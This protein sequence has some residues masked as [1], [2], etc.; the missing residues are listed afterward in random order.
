M[1]KYFTM[2]GILLVVTLLLAACSSSSP[3]PTEAP[4]EEV[5]PTEAPQEEP[6]EAPKEE[7]TEEAAPEETEDTGA[8]MGDVI[9]P[10]PGEAVK[11]VL[12]PKF[13]GILVF[14]QANEGAQEAAAELQNPEK[15]EF[16][17]PTPENSVAG[18]I[19]IVTTAATQGMDA[20]MISNNAGDQIVP[21]AATAKDAGMTVVTWDS[22]I[23][24]AENEDLFIA[25]VDF[26][27][28]GKVMADMA[29]SIMGEDGGQFAV[30]S[31]S[32]DASN[33]NA[34]IAALEDVLKDDAYANL[35]LVDIVYGND[36]SEDSYNQALAL[37]DK[38]PDLELI[39]AP[40]TVGIAAAAKAM[41]DEGLCDEVKVSGLGLPA[42]ML[43]YT[44][45][46]CAPE[47][48]L[49][50][51]VDL[52][53]LTYY[54]TYLLA[55]GQMDAAEGVTF[56][57]GRMGTYTIE[58]DPTRDEG[59]RVLMGPFTV[60]NKD[61]VEAAA[62]GAEVALLP[63]EGADEVVT[64]TVGQ[65]IKM[66]LLPKFLGI[67]VFDQ[68]NNGAQEAA[69][70][71][72]NPEKLEFLGPTPENSVAGQIDIVTTAATQGVDAIM[73]SNNAGDQIVP[74]ATA[75]KEAGMT[76]VTWDSPIPSAEG[77]DIFIAQVDFDE[78][79][80]VM[81]DMARSIMGEDGG[82]FAVLSASPDASNQNAW[83]AALE[84][85]L[86]DDAYANLEL[87]DIVYG[88]DQSEDSYNQ[89]L[90]LVDKYPDLELIMAPTTVGIAAAAK[91][92]QDEGLCDEVKVSGLGLPAEMVSYTLNGCAPEFALWSFDDLGYLTYYVTYMLAT[93]D[94]QGVE[95]ETFEA[96]RMG[97]YTIEK[98]P[99]RD[100][101]LR[102]LMGPFTVYTA[103]NVEDA[104]K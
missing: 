19:D 70:E 52:G 77:E 4:K 48:A 55:T 35:E 14:D 72:E 91:A 63:E 11:M 40:T 94:L 9:V 100:A 3:A 15:L 18:Q 47:F 68:A 44:L 49:W 25:Q 86:Q 98:D 12:L 74:A 59:L 50:S 24:S 30:L 33:Q 17:G 39:M 90:A 5:A 45:N 75:A 99:T 1:K 96:G 29:R 66:V 28:T 38:Y 83:I 41:Q 93:G 95:G 57:A 13:L 69:A 64:A 7:S 16:L 32:P 73:I 89:A 53:Y 87:V 104:A 81:A 43:S 36:Q 92:M 10:Q 85:V 97:T 78:T 20:I 51:F 71:L 62:G 42:E 79:G 6:T 34:W 37:V 2:I 23:P 46:G 31:A 56:E 88:N 26:D 22:P 76:V 27:E 103:E 67:L 65:A 80:K 8:A 82:Q 54:T 101:G 60:Y 21:A 58:K 61:N 84:E 102:V